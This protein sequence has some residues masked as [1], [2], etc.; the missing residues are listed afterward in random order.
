MEKFKELSIE[1][2]QE[3]AGGLGF[4]ATIGAG[5]IVATGVAIISD[6]DN[7]KAGL[8]GEPEIIDNCK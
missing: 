6:W 1:E 5:L 4:W 3:T 2:M 8:R 7:F